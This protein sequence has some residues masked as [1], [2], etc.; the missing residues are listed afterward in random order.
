MVN[1]AGLAMATMDTIKHVGGNPANF[2]DVGGSSSPD[3]VVAAFRLILK[4]PRVKAILINI[5]GG[6]TRCDDIARGILQSLEQMKVPVPIVVRLV[7][8]N[9]EEGRRLLEGTK[10]G[11]AKSLVEGARKATE[12]GGRA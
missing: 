8:T 11:T 1:G 5:F 4:N 12:L 10:L 7:G 3:K 9:E 2:L 6:I